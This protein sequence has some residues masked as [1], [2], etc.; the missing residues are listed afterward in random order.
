MSNYDPRDGVFVVIVYLIGKSV[1]LVS[2]KQVF[3]KSIATVFAMD[4]RFGMYAISLCV[5]WR[6]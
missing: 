5:T 2:E 1:A 6:A 4:V 3:W